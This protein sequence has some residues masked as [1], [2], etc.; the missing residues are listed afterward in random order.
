MTTEYEKELMKG[1]GLRESLGSSICEK[2][3][4]CNECSNKLEG[5]QKA[6]DEIKEKIEELQE[7]LDYVYHNFSN[8]YI[9][10]FFSKLFEE[11]GF[12]EVTK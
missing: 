8:V 12:D 9:K 2:D 11:L 7:G 6:R 4:L 3:N 1:C 5:Y 10:N